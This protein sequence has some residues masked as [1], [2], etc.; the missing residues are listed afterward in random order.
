MPPVCLAG[1][2]T[3][4]Q[5]AAHGLNQSDDL[6]VFLTTPREYPVPEKIV[7]SPWYRCVQTAAPLALKLKKQIHLDH[8]PAEWYSHAAP[9]TG[10]HPRPIVEGAASMSKH[11]PPGLIN[12]EYTSTVYPSRRGESLREVHDRLDLFAK[13]FVRRMDEEGVRSVVIFAHAAT[14]I[15]LGRAVSRL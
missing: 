15:A 1:A 8:G 2:L 3:S 9:G 6:A 13:T 14:V 12:E 5:L 4:S 11:F 10:L 7:A